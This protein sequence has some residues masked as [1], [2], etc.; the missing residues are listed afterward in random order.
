M[1]EVFPSD[2]DLVAR[3]RSG[4]VEAFG[5]LVERNQDYIYN[6]VYHLVGSGQDA[7]DIAQDVFVQAYKSIARF[8]GRAKFTTWLYGIMLNSVRSFWRRRSRRP[9]FVLGGP[10]EDDERP[11]P[12][13]GGDNPLEATMREERVRTVRRAIA[14]L[15]DDLRE[16]VVLRDI[17]GLTYEELAEVLDVPDGTVK[18]RLHRARQALKEK[19]Q[20]FFDR[21]E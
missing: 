7:E 17:R 13:A 4:D 16:I 11:D 20:P 2:A 18:S 19:L 21:T 8:E 6:V 12:Q 3:A 15:D 10:N 14:G 1:G 9:T 5:L